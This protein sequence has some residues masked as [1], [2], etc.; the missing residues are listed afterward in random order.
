MIAPRMKGQAFHPP[1][2]AFRLG[3]PRRSTVPSSVYPLSGA[4]PSSL[5]I[6][7]TSLG[8]WI[9]MIPYFISTRARS[10]K[11]HPGYPL[12]GPTL[13]FL[14]VNLLHTKSSRFCQQA[15]HTHV[16]FRFEGEREARKHQYNLRRCNCLCL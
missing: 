3:L 9:Q 8:T 1:V 16:V 6:F 7:S 10:Y 15:N 14:F 4:D 2:L 5:V 11:H 13:F 12:D